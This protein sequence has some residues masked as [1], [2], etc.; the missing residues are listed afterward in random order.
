M[1]ALWI[2]FHWI[3]IILV[4]IL[5][6]VAEYA[7]R[8]IIMVIIGRSIHGHH[9]GR[10]TQ[11]SAEVKKRQA[12]VM[13]LLLIMWKV[14]VFASA[15]IGILFIIFPTIN[16]LPFFASAGILG[17]VIGF[18]S[19][20]TIK[21][22]IAGTFIITENQFR[23]GDVIEVEGA[24]LNGAGTVEHIS[25]RSTVL[26][27]NSG[28][29][30]YISNGNIIHVIN[31]TMGY[32]KVNFTLSVAPDTDIDKVAAIIDKTGEVLAGNE[33][34]QNK[35]IEAPHFINLGAFSDTVLELNITGKTVAGEQWAVASELKKQLLKELQHHHG[36]K[37]SHTAG[38]N[39]SVV[40]GKKKK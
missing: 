6:I 17:A 13:G 24:G 25:L 7:G 20:S 31:K 12:T 28:N 10:P 16:I 8:K 40:S 11:P 26:R 34:W 5:A 38:L 3:A 29:V 39:L 37:I 36:V 9:F 15:V 21:D 4:V 30:H 22:I 27:D 23:V 14:I 35:I 18:G 1:L 19:Q 32:S 2:T 33:K